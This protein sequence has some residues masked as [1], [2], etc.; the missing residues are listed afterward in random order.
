MMS[1]PISGSRQVA[2]CASICCRNSPDAGAWV[3]SMVSA[4]SL[5]LSRNFDVDVA[6]LD[7]HRIGFR[8]NHRRQARNLAGSH[9]EPRAVAGTLDRHFP[10][11][12]LAERVFLVGAGVADRVEVVIL[13]VN[14]AD[15]LAVDLDSHHRLEPQ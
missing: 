7:R 5:S 6:V 3:V 11:L 8:W 1:S 2:S 12:A 14:Q 13:G 4:I 9:V 15:R 10:K